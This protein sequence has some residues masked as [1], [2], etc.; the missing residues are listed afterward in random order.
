MVIPMQS[1][2]AKRHWRAGDTAVHLMAHRWFEPNTCHHLRKRPA[3]WDFP[4]MRAVFFL[5][6]VVSFRAAVVRR[7]RVVADV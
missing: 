2:Q 4:A 1:Q 7:V 5:S 3:S 6:R